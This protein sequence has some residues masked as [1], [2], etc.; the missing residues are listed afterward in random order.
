M[1][2]YSSPSLQGRALGA[3]FNRKNASRLFAV[4]FL[5]DQFGYA[6]AYG[7]SLLRTNDFTRPAAVYYEGL[8]VVMNFSWNSLKD[9]ASKINNAVQR[10]SGP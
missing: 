2:D 3:V 8:G 7:G 9:L 1:S 4:G 6:G 5:V 10:P